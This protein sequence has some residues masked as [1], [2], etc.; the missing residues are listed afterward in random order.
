MKVSV[1]THSSDINV[2]FSNESQLIIKN[3]VKITNIRYKLMKYIDLIIDRS[4]CNIF[5]IYILLI[6]VVSGCQTEDLSRVDIKSFQDIKGEKYYELNNLICCNDLI[7]DEKF[8]IINDWCSDNGFFHVYEYSPIKFIKSFGKKGR[9]PGEF[10]SPLFCKNITNR[11]NVFSVFDLN[12]RLKVD[13]KLSDIGSEVPQEDGIYIVNKE[14]LS[15]D[16]FP[17]INITYIDSCVY[18]NDVNFAG[19]LFFIYDMKTNQKILIDYLPVE[20]YNNHQF[21]KKRSYIYENK[22]VV[23]REEGR[24]AVGMS[25]FNQIH[26]FDLKGNHLKSVSVGDDTLPILNELYFAGKDSFFY[27]IDIYAT[28]DFVYILWG[29]QKLL[30]YE[31]NIVTDSF[32]IVFS[33]EGLH[34]KTYKIQNSN[35][36]GINPD[37]TKLFAAVKDSDG[38]TE[39]SGYDIT[40][41][42]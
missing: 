29:G 16:I 20:F 34:M 2:K 9:G 5:S 36:I 38:T 31:S 1:F 24:I 12:L 42:K 8:L 13:Y 4:I 40:I 30:D 6:L 32:V 23:N 10:I 15:D 28:N 39:I 37:N 27:C 14:E 7:I 33:W 17:C 21:I 18:G 26:F 11:S 3:K 25:Y 41:N 35:T 19:G 22:L